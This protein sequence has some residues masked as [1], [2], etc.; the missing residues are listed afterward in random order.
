MGREIFRAVDFEKL[1]CRFERVLK[2]RKSLSKF[3]MEV[4]GSVRN[5][6]MSSANAANLY[7]RCLIWIPLMSGLSLRRLRRGSS[8]R[9]KIKG[10]SGQPWRVPFDTE[11]AFDR[12][13]L[14]WTFAVGPEYNA[15]M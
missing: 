8:D 4:R 2:V 7:V 1:I 14:T 9:M 12:Q 15:E 3:G 10:E 5:R 6:R 11:K 13:P